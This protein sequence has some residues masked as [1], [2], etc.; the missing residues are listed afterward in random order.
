MSLFVLY[1][2]LISCGVEEEKIKQEVK[3]ASKEAVDFSGSWQRE[4]EDLI[5]T[6]FIE[7]SGE[8]VTFK[9]KQEAKDGSWYIEC[10]DLGECDKVQDGNIIEHYSFSIQISEDKQKLITNWIV[11]NIEMDE[12]QPYIDEIEMSES[13]NEIVSRP[14][15]FDE[16]G[17]KVY[18]E[19]EYRFFKIEE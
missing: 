18:G 6:I 9:W 11:K 8:S 15:T 4:E 10:N 17:R 13:G 16:E 1:L 3:E 5:S 14:I 2:F 12:I 19:R 7:Q